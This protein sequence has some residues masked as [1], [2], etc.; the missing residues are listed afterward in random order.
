MPRPRPPKPVRTTRSRA[1]RSAFLVAYTYRIGQRLAEVN[2][3]VI[4][5][6]EA[7]TSRSILPVLAARSADIDA[8]VDAMFGSLRRPRRSAGHDA[9]GWASGRLAADR[10]QLTAG[11]LSPG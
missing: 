2:D 11:Q 10:A 9:A 6:A 3:E 4:S 5:T 7:E 1:F 8:T